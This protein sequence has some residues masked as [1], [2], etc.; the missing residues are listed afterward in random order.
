MHSSVSA[1]RVLGRPKT[2]KTRHPVVISAAKLIEG[3]PVLAVVR[4]LRRV[5]RKTEVRIEV[6]DQA[7]TEGIGRIFPIKCGGL[8]IIYT[9]GSRNF[10]QHTDCKAKRNNHEDSMNYIC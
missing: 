3:K 9:V 6:K 8:G 10:L 7:S 4:R 2:S 5:V 1:T